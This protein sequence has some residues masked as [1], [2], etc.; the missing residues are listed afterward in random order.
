MQA[1]ILDC[2]TV[3]PSG[4]GVPPYLSTYVR[5]AYS[6]LRSTPGVDKIRYVTIDDLR[7][8]SLPLEVPAAGLTNPLTYSASVNREHATELVTNA[9]L[10]VVVA[11]DKV[12]S[13]HLH[14]VNGSMD[15]IAHVA[16]NALGRRILLGP[17][18]SFSDDGVLAGLFD[19]V[20]SHT[21][22]ASHLLTNTSAPAPYQLMRR[23]RHEYDGLISQMNWEPIA[24]IELY[25]GCTRRVFCSF[26]HEPG[27]NPLVTFRAVEDVLHEVKLLYTAGV[28]NF[29]LGQQTC[30]F[31]Y[32]HRDVDAIERLLSG[33]RE[34]CPNLDVLHI[35][36]ADPLAVAS[37]SGSQIARSVARF[38]TEGNCA[39]MGQESFDPN[40]IARNTLTS[41]Q[42]ILLRAIEHINEAGLTVGSHG[43]PALLPGVNL[44]YGLPGESD[45]THEFNLRGLAAILDG[46]YQCHRT[47]IRQVRTYPNTPLS[48]SQTPSLNPDYF[49]QYKAEITDAYEIPM[50]Q[51]VYPIG[52]ILRDLHS[53]F[54]T[55]RGT[56]HRRLGSYS[57]QVVERG[58]T[59][60]LFEPADLRVVDH[61][62]RYIY[63]ERVAA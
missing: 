51:R 53:F 42:A 14:A 4:L 43:L 3:E 45:Q 49:D 17:M 39:A 63:G 31:S 56:W 40:V 38:C 37:R 26:C 41:T 20:H 13:V 8:P 9:D 59:R 55:E 21:I 7:A 35:D 22:T 23:H 46:G 60:H 24:E 61:A 34:S 48:R 54:V 11:G 33:I 44:I 18:S 52:R 30:F 57:I 25:R 1:V 47:N 6:A 16:S 10:L 36:N 5:E 32:Q 27:K 2:Y 58:T 12:P 62:G 15:E 29:R 50:K 28:R 19:A